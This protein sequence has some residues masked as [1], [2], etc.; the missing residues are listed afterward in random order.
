MSRPKPTRHVLEE[1]DVYLASLTETLL[2]KASRARLLEL[3]SGS[4]KYLDQLLQN[5]TQN[6][7]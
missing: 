5:L 2:E 4:G 6:G 1:V 3:E 7:I